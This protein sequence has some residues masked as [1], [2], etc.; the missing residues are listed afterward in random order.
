MKNTLSILTY[1]L[2]F[3]KALNG[4]VDLTKQYQPDIVCVQEFPVNETTVGQLE[5][6]GYELADYTASFFKYFRLY[7]VATFY[8]PKIIIH[9]NG[10]VINVGRGLYEI[11]LFLLR[12]SPYPRT[13]LTNNFTT[14]FGR[15]PFRVC[16][17]HLSALQSTNKVRMRQLK[18]VL[19]FLEQ[20]P[21]KPTIVAGDFNY[22]YKRKVLEALLQNQ[23]FK[24]A[25]NNLFFTIENR[26]LKLFK[27]RMKPDYIWYK[28]FSKRR[29][30]RLDR[31]QSDHFPIFSE[32]EF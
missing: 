29:T 16:N 13:L 2:C 18:T 7:S 8:N 20:Q 26:L 10:Q 24:E 28:Y 1:N 15:Q 14:R 6:A 4:L 11:L 31:Q 30:V 23:G 27:I 9:Q 5:K 17:V 19:K 21:L 3:G 22:V 12:F 32:F 25:T